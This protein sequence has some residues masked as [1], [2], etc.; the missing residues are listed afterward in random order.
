MDGKDVTPLTIRT[1]IACHE[2]DP[3][4]IYIPEYNRKGRPV[5]LPKKAAEDIISGGTLRDVIKK[6]T[7]KVYCVP[8]DDRGVILDMDTM[9]DY[10][11]ILEADYSARIF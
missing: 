10:R 2:N 6:H 5:L 11:K 4:R 8:V 9:D 1:L 7:E 3:G